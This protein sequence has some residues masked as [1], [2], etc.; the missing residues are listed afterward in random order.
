MSTVIGQCQYLQSLP[1]CLREL[2]TLG[3]GYLEGSHLLHPEQS[4]F[5]PKRST[6]DALLEATN[7]WGR[8]LDSNELAGITSKFY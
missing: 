6:M 8:A 4:G 2:S 3:Y 5:H 1:E 7:N